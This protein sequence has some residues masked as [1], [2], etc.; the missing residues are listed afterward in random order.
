MP[1]ALGLDPNVALNYRGPWMD[2]AAMLQQGNL[3]RQRMGLER[4][5]MQLTAGMRAADMQMREKELATERSEKAAADEAMMQGFKLLWEASPELKRLAP[6]GDWGN[7]APNQVRGLLA[8]MEVLA[9]KQQM[10]QA[11][12]MLRQ[13]QA[14][15]RQEQVNA[16]AL[17]AT[18]QEPWEQKRLGRY[19]DQGGRDSKTVGALME[20]AREPQIID[21]GNGA[22]AVTYDNTLQIVKPDAQAAALL[23]S[24]AAP[25]M[26][27]DKRYYH[28]GRTWSQ[29]KE[30]KDTKLKLSPWE[31]KSYTVRQQE[32]QK[33]IG[34]V[35]RQID[36]GN[37]RHGLDWL[38]GKRFDEERAELQ[39]EL[40]AVNAV[41]EG[42]RPTEAA[43]EGEPAAAA[44][45]AQSYR[46]ENGQIHFSPNVDLAIQVNQA[47]NNGD[48]APADALEIL[49]EG[50]LPVDEAKFKQFFG[51]Q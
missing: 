36:K 13:Q 21:V 19:L 31:L 48:L 11:Q 28:T 35:N 44:A 39:Q 32:L 15:L 33:Q 49:K 16:Q 7:V 43:A 50:K 6:V 38:W 10:D 30:P 5:Q 42:R 24:G 45:P 20:L 27:P 4:E 8:G 2:A 9:Q 23:A 46:I 47:L 37:K 22:K 14:A 51:L 29:V 3:A 12:L 26:S 18:L 41:L 17:K 40:N 1:G 34:E 25:K